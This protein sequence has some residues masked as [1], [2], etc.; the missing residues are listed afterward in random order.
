M[1]KRLS[2]AP[3][4]F[5]CDSGPKAMAMLES[6]AFSLLICDLNMPKMDGLQVL[7]IVRRKYPQL[8][9]VVMTSVVEEQF[10]ARAYSLGVDLFWQKP[11]DEQEI[12]LFLECIEAVLQREEAGGFR[13]IQ[14]KSLVDIIQLECMS[15]SSC[16]LKITNGAVVGNVWIQAGEVID[17]AVGDLLGEEAFK[18]IM[19]WKAGNFENLPAEPTRTRTIFNSYQ[20]L[21]LDTAQVLDESQALESGAA[22]QDEIHEE[23]AK[24]LTPLQAS[25]KV[26]GVEFILAAPEDE[27]KAHESWGVE[28]PETLAK[29][30]HNAFKAFHQL[31]D[32][33][34]AGTLK[35]VTGRGTQRHFVL[36]GAAE[37]KLILGIH[38][39]QSADDVRETV[40]NVLSKWAS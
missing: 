34:V 5:A 15:Q 17:A 24:R 19:A 25:S 21:L 6:D 36:V 9:T 3:E 27:K 38:R 31:G 14:S 13:G 35:Q 26:N 8:K 20:G 22:P 40:K 29:Y 7:S 10:R 37:R 39:G 1:L 4:V 12:K 33:Y 16:V 23:A 11:G 30:V 32:Q 28:N 18:K 2:C